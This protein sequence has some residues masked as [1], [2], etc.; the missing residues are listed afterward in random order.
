M[1]VMP[2][3]DGCLDRGVGRRSVNQHERDLRALEK[4]RRLAELSFRQ[5]VRMIA[6]VVP[7][8]FFL[9]VFAALVKS[10]DRSIPVLLETGLFGAVLF[11]FGTTIAILCE[12][13]FAKMGV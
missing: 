6:L 11:P 2:Y 12:K 13:A 10:P 1:G 8:G 5:A 3:L 7:A 9:G 4:R